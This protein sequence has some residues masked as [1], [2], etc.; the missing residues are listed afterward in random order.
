MMVKGDFIL[1]L[2]VLSE[3]LFYYYMS[4]FLKKETPLLWVHSIYPFKKFV[5]F[6]IV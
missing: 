1:Y 4:F 2:S 5:K 3:F 6:K